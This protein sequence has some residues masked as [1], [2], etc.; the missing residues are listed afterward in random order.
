L[1][2]GQADDSTQPGTAIRRAEA[3]VRHNQL[4]V[5]WE[6]SPCQPRQNR[7]WSAGWIPPDN[8]VVIRDATV[9]YLVNPVVRNPGGRTAGRVGM[10]CFERGDS[11]ADSAVWSHRGAPRCS[12]CRPRADEDGEHSDGHG[13]ET[14][15]DQT[16]LPPPVR[17]SNERERPGQRDFSCRRVTCGGVRRSRRPVG[18][19]EDRRRQ[20]RPSS[21]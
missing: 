4:R 2:G 5:T 17:R 21:R 18:R 12:R 15:H 13:R 10:R 9:A 20:W 6:L 16:T 19:V 11:G 14:T 7:G 1:D 8:H 3:V